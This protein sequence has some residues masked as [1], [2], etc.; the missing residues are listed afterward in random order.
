[1]NKVKE[2]H[3]FTV[4]FLFVLLYLLWKAP[5][6]FRKLF[7]LKPKKIYPRKKDFKRGVLFL[8]GSI[9]CGAISFFL[10]KSMSPS[11]G[12][13]DYFNLIFALIFGYSAYSCVGYSIH[14][15]FIGDEIKD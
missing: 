4:I 2:T 13:S 7:G 12:Y 1:M 6:Y 3:P 9:G 10:L 11:H 8:F 14:Y 15:C 5:A